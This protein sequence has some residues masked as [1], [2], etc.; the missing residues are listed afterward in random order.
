MCLI[1]EHIMSKLLQNGIGIIENMYFC[2][3]LLAIIIR[4]SAII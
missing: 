4:L 3:R 1:N 2:Y